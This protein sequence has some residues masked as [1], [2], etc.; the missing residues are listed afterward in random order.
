[1]NVLELEEKKLNKF[2][3]GFKSKN[4][5]TIIPS[6]I[7]AK[8][9]E[10]EENILLREL[11]DDIDIETIANNH[12]RTKGG[13]ISRQKEVKTKNCRAEFY[14]NSAPSASPVLATNGKS[15]FPFM[16]V[17]LIIFGRG[18]QKIPK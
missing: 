9:S 11:H 7:G 4:P 14:E 16:G 13:I 1:M 3:L 6:N 15:Q 18:S 10:S 5:N 8:W 12:N 17:L 2:Q